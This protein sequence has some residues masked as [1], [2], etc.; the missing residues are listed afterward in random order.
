MS[1]YTPTMGI[2]RM[3]YLMQ[4]ESGSFPRRTAEGEWDRA[5]AAH[6]AQK[7]A[8]WEAMQGEMEWEYGATHV[9][10]DEPVSIVS[11]LSEALD[12]QAVYTKWRGQPTNVFMRTKAI[13]AGP[14]LSVPDTTNTES[15]GKP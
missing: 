14:W 9:Y 7:R 4:W 1:E 15:E 2:L 8:E 12:A 3:T 11:S 6:D 5:L 13:P 10:P